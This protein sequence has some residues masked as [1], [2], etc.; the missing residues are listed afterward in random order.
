[1]NDRIVVTD[2]AFSDTHHEQAA[3]QRIGAEFA[4]FSARTEAETI[5]AVARA[6]IAFVNFAPM[7]RAVLSKMKPGATI[8]RYG[9]GV[10]NVDL[11][12]A[13][14]LGIKV[15]NVPDY[16][17]ETVADH[18]AASLLALAR[19]IPNFDRTIHTE[20]WTSPTSLGPLRSLRQHMIGY[21]GFGRIAQAV[22][23]RLRAFGAQGIAYDPFC[24]DEVLYDA[25][26]ERVELDDLARRSTALTLHAP[27]TSETKNVIDGE[28]L[29][30]MPDRA[31]IVNTSRGGLI[32]EAALEIALNEGRI[33]GAILDVTSVEPLPLDSS[34]RQARGLVLTPHAAFYDEESLDNLQRLASEE[35]VRAAFGEPLR[36][37]VA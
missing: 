31:I 35:A 4:E 16:G 6:S 1:M 27:L 14:E 10:D 12:A 5:D 36:C 28:F 18:A 21:L 2:H 29:S 22:H 3:A 11:D 13:R 30:R 8:I 7:T 32:D 17:V 15:S 20:G 37:Q 24:A 23:R 9:V 33:S 25:A 26:V 19:Q 34:L